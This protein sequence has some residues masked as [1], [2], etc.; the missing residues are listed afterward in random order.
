VSIFFK[1]FLTR[2][3]YAMARLLSVCLSVCLSFVSHRC[4]VAKPCVI[5]ENFLHD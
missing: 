4:I 2:Y 5:G 1:T 3:S